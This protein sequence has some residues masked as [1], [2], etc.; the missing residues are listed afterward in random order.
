MRPL[1]A[2]EESNAIKS[3]WATLT[4]NGLTPVGQLVLQRLF[5]DVPEVRSLFYRI[6][7]ANVEGETYSL[8]C[9]T[10]NEKFNSHA[11]RVAWGLDG[12]VKNL[13][14]TK[15]VTEKSINL[16]RRHKKHNVQ[17]HYFDLLGG[18]L[19]KVI[20]QALKI[21]ETHPTIQAWAKAY[22]VIATALKTGLTE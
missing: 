14:N 12:I 5:Q 6:E 15:V 16:G 13:D 8:D 20:S 9:L 7:I 1:F 22:G 19:V 18:V 3:S 21:E 11:K 4:N 10:K 17:P 2:E